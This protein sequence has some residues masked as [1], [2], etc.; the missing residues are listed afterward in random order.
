MLGQPGQCFMWLIQCEMATLLFIVYCVLCLRKWCS[1]YDS[2]AHWPKIPSEDITLKMSFLTA[3][4]SGSLC[5]E[6]VTENLIFL[7]CKNETVLLICQYY[8]YWRWD[9]MKMIDKC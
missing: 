4:A 3:Y 8:K 7:I 2:P 1:W 5:Y 9:L 6:L